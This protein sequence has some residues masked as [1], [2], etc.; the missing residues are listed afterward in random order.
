MRG[1]G[2]SAPLTLLTGKFLLIY[3]GKRGKKKKERKK[4][5][6]N[7]EEEKKKGKLKKGRWKMKRGPF[8]FC[9]FFFAFFFFF[10]FC[11]SLFKT[12]EFFFFFFGL[13]KCKMAILYW[14][15]S[16]SR[17][18]RNQ[19]KWLCPSENFSSFAP[20]YNWHIHLKEGK[21]SWKQGK[22]NLV[23]CPVLGECT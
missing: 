13:P 11:F 6:E 22:T 17:Q 10:F 4:E 8:F 23:L 1:R 9:F 20:A 3:W 18:E 2:Q 21:V 16:N 5:R 15:K 7:G 12:T 14:E 19:E